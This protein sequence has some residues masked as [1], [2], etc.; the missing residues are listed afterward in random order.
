MHTPPLFKTDRAASFAFAEARGFGL[1]SAYDGRVP[2]ASPVPFCID[3][4][5]DGT[6]RLAFHLARNNPLIGLADGKAHWLMA[7][8]GADA[9]VSAD[10]YVSPDQVPTWLYQ[11]VHLSGP[12]TVMPAQD[13]PGHLDRLSE[14]FETR[15]APKRPWTTAKMT[16]GRLKAMQNGIVGL[17]ITVEDIH[18]SFKLNQHKSDADHVAVATALASRPDTG[19]QTLAERMVALRP[20]LDYNTPAAVSG[21]AD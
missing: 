10:W 21:A 19:A 17:V 2:V 15:L 18:G 4:A 6:P 3:Y 14:K 16:A 7:V 9:Y 8:T 20:Q 5:G 13:L 12:V 1:V 11:A